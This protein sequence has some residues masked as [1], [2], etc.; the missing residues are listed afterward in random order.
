MAS[1]RPLAYI[2]SLMDIAREKFARQ[3]PGAPVEWRSSAAP[4]PFDAAVATM[5]ERVA[6][7]RAGTA[8]EL[9]WLLEHDPLYTAGT[10]ADFADLLAPDMFPV[11]KTGRGGEFT[12]HGPGQRIAYL[13]LDLAAR[14]PG[15]GPDLKSFVTHLEQWIIATLAVFDIA[16]EVRTGRVGVWVDTSDGGEAKIAALGIRVRRWV[17]F[18]G[19][20]LNVAPDLT[21]YDGIVACGIKDHGVTSLQAMG[22]DVSMDEV[23][24]VLK[25]EFAKRFG[26]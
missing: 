20:S 12:Y 25:Q 10:S 14:T 5:E 2:L 11:H 26:A 9:V 6:A 22:V 15:K 13:M 16:G 17:T 4:E 21:H 18:H 1:A 8:P 3:E 7:I 24:A 23:D 19:I